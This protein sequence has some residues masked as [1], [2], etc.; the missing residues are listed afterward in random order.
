MKSYICIDIGGTNIK[1]GIIREDAVI[2][3]NHETP[4]EAHLGGPGILH[5]VTSIISSYLNKA[6]IFSPA[7]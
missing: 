1:Y 3:E 2:L 6:S 7:F 4:T 5:K